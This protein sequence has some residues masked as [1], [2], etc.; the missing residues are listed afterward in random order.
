MIPRRCFDGTQFPAFEQALLPDRLSFRVY[1]LR[2]RVSLWLNEGK[3]LQ[4]DEC[5]KDKYRLYREHLFHRAHRSATASYDCIRFATVLIEGIVEGTPQSPQQPQLVNSI[6]YLR[7]GGR[8]PRKNFPEGPI[9]T[10]RVEASYTLYTFG[11]RP[12]ITYRSAAAAT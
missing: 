8:A 5:T 6:I 10:I 11:G 3:R 7:D 4:C 2:H 12:C 1:K 9:P